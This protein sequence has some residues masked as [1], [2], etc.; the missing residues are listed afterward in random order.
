MP[1]FALADM[2][3]HQDL[4]PLARHAAAAMLGA[5]DQPTDRATADLLLSL[6]E[7]DSAVRFLAS[8]SGLQPSTSPKSGCLSGSFPG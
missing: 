2:A 3:T 5:N 4:L 7:R 1:E 6:F 8:G